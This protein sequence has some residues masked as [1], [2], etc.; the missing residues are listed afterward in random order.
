MAVIATTFGAAIVLQPCLPVAETIHGDIIRNIGAAHLIGTALPQ[1]DSAALHEAI[2][3]R[4]VNPAP[5][6][7]LEGKAGIYP[8][9]VLA[10]ALLEAEVEI[11]A[12]ATAQAVQVPAP[13][14]EDQ[15]ALGAGTFPAAA[16]E[17]GMRSEG[18]R[19]DTAV[20]EHARAEAEALPALAH[21]E[22]EV[23]VSVAEAA[24]AGK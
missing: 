22:A 13:W 23:E 16:E 15:I 3:W 12:L 9:L 18:E 21:A 1:I 17:T 8:A 4:I 5:G 2:L 14:A 20:R 24:G 6:N 7:R 10:M 11:V 19:A